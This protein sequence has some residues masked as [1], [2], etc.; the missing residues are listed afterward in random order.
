MVKAHLAQEKRLGGLL[1]I[2]LRF[3]SSKPSS[4]FQNVH[5]LRSNDFRRIPRSCFT[6]VDSSE[7]TVGFQV[8]TVYKRFPVSN[9]IRGRQ[10][11]PV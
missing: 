5:R 3:E 10:I 4:R 8:L 6:D 2:S 11:I 7:G 9:I 1:S